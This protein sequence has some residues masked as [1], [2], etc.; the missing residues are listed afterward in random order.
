MCGNGDRTMKTPATIDTVFAAHPRAVGESYWAHAAT[1]TRF[2]LTMLAGGTAC[3][4]HAVVP[5]LFTTTGSDT[6]RRLH[7]RMS[8]RHAPAVRSE[9]P[10]FCY[11]I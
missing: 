5:A 1:A 11:E 8:S 2:G 7:G 6:V 3:L 10:G 4:V 9:A